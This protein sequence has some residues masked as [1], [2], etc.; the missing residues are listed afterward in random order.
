MGSLADFE[1]RILPCSRS[2]VASGRIGRAGPRAARGARS[3][4]FTLAGAIAILG[5]CFSGVA[6]ADN[7]W[8][9]SSLGVSKDWL[10]Q[11]TNAKNKN[12]PTSR[13]KKLTECTEC[14]AKVDRLQAL[15]DAWYLAEYQAGA[16]LKSA[17]VQNKDF[18]EGSAQQTKGKAMQQDAS[19]GLGGLSPADI[20]KKSKAKPDPAIPQDPSK[21]EASIKEAAA[22]L[23][24]C[25]DD[26]KKKAAA[27]PPQTPP[28]VSV[29]P[30]VQP[31]ADHVI[32]LDFI[33]NKGAEI[34]PQDVDAALN[35]VNEA[36]AASGVGFS[37][38]T[39]TP[40]NNP[41]MPQTPKEGPGENKSSDEQNKVAKE[42]AKIAKDLPAP[43]GAIP[44]K[45][46]ENFGSDR[47]GVADIS[48]ITINGVVLIADP[49]SVVRNSA[50][51][52]NF[53]H[54][55]AHELGH[56][57]GL[58]HEALE[59]DK[60]D[61][62]VE[63]GRY[64][65]PDAMGNGIEKSGGEDAGTFTPDQIDVIKK[66]AVKFYEKTATTGGTSGGGGQSNKR[67]RKPKRHAR[68]EDDPLIMEG[69]QPA[70]AHG[71]PSGSNSGG[72]P[73]YVVKPDEGEQSQPEEQP[74]PEV[75]NPYDQPRPD[76]PV[77]PH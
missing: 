21:L 42:A 49:V 53:A 15:L 13:L 32:D 39:F 23:Q 67:P 63:N 36:F 11:G 6:R 56:V 46:V 68:R 40:V 54:V 59:S 22:A 14:Q 31:K 75:P 10:E 34:T 70:P 58:E 73:T 2:A 48:G 61:S 3:F 55:L 77:P 41:D 57:L 16:D 30:A 7:S 24:K 5:V 62:R 17:G 71:H 45:V 12:A 35:K 9:L 60:K 28:A 26:C 18:T 25:L 1:Y 29:Q 76:I 43:H 38:K 72:S 52:D 66:K 50:G 4:L 8:D 64:I 65:P 69:Y 33:I 19:A 37:R 27:P 20:G 44:V 47:P 51:R 74:S